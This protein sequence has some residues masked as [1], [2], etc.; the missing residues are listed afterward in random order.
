VHVLAAGGV[1]NFGRVLRAVR[2][3][4]TPV[5]VAGLYD[6]GAER[7][8]M[9]ALASTGLAIDPATPALD[10]FGFFV[11]VADL[12]DELIRALGVDAVID[13]LDRQGELR[14]FETL[15]KQPRHAGRPVDQQLRRFMGTRSMRKI[16]YGR[17]LVEALDPASAPDPLRRVLD[18]VIT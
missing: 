2:E 18:A 4:P 15:G 1:T 13:L 9:R 10:R 3:R 8:V 7:H 17:L 16:R 14:S 6:Q 11:C 12:E 5:T